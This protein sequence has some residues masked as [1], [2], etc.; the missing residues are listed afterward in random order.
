M[1][2]GASDNSSFLSF[3]PNK[4]VNYPGS[5]PIALLDN[6]LL[7]LP[8]MSIIWQGDLAFVKIPL[9]YMSLYVCLSVAE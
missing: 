8:K 6:S 4:H 3:A 5:P 7:H 1:S 9:P 2:T